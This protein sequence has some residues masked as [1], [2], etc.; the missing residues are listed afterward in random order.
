M[1]YC[2]TAE[3]MENIL[4]GHCDENFPGMFIAKVNSKWVAVDATADSHYIFVC[5]FTTLKAAI[6]FLTG[7]K[8]VDLSG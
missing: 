2:K 7:T 8:G 5:S 6:D 3:Q 4:D 1:I